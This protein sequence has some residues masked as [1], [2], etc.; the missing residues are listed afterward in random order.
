MTN[1]K[2]LQELEDMLAYLAGDLKF[3]RY[4]DH[5]FVDALEMAID[6]MKTPAVVVDTRFSS[7][8]KYINEAN[9]SQTLLISPLP[10]LL[11][12]KP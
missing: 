1:D 7:Q 2:A 4:A 12:R 9:K 6:I 10:V 8:L 11:V 5:D 3:P